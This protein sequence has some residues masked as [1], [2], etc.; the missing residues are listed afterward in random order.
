M[1]IWKKLSKFVILWIA[2]CA[3]FYGA[4]FLI[5]PD[6][7]TKS[8]AHFEILLSTNFT[9]LILTQLSMVLGTLSA[10]Y[11]MDRLIDFNKNPIIPKIVFPSFLAGLILGFVFITACVTTLIFLGT[12]KL[13]FIGFPF[14]LTYYLVA[15]LLVAISEELLS[16]GYILRNLLDKI[17]EVTAILLSSLFFAVLHG[18]N[19]SFGLIQFLNLF[20]FGVLFSLL[21]IKRMNL[22]GPIGFHLSL[23]LTQGP[24]FGFPVSGFKTK[25][26]FLV[27]RMQGDRFSGGNFGIEG[28]IILTIMVT[29]L[30]AY[31]YRDLVKKRQVL[32]L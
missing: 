16:R 29:L 21:F 10:I 32:E 2:C 24:I 4:V 13:K 26:I 1:N 27:E 6:A 7:L 17:D 11:I 9:F 19:S 31:H 23:N 12:V 14:E 5:F 22:S 8:G 15:F 28:S 20:L 25:S 18:L 3:L 30:I